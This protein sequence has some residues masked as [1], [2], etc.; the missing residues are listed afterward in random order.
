M[1]NMLFTPTQLGSLPLKNRIVMAPLTRSRAI[2]NLPNELM[3]QYY[4]LRADAGLI[5]TE[6]T[7]PS[8]NGLG[9]PRIPGLF[10]EE[11]VQGW[12][13][14]TDGVHQAGGRIFV[15]LMHTGRVSH[16]ANMPAGA[17]VLAPSA[18]AVPGE[19]WTDTDGMQPHPVPREMSEADIAQ[20]IA[21]YAAS[22]KLAIEAG[23]DG[24]EL[25]AANGYLIDQFLN[26]ASNQRHD[27]W[28]GSV[29]NRIR[30]AVEVA[31]ATVA[32]IGAER[33]G[34]RISPY[35]VF[36]AQVPDAEMDALYL[37]LIDE[38]NTLG[39]LYIHIVDHSAMGA[40]EVSPELKANIRAAFNGQYILSG[41]YDVA[42][43]NADL[44]AQRGDLVAFGRPFISNPDLVAKLKLGQELVAPD[45]STFYTPGEK[46]YTD[47]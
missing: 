16:P 21:E 23:F 42:R 41:G 26:T 28:G 36:N 47:Y 33:V 15:Q 30:F 7:S 34:M 46:G 27:R 40:P 3:A 35:G 11:Q 37:R 25:H 45:F 18:V 8:P 17:S 2:G 44:D 31:R 1:N 32:A 19:M 12:R 24:V 13:R 9:Y 10:N 5:I 39:L 20:S 38:L 4:R 43:A 22:A 14:V 6:G 29:E